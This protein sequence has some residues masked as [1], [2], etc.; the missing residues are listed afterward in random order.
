M[1]RASLVFERV[2]GLLEGVLASEPAGEIEELAAFVAE[3]E[4]GMLVCFMEYERLA[5]FR[6]VDG[7][8]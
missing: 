3:G 2:V 6:A 5:A 4:E 7:L 8:E 1:E